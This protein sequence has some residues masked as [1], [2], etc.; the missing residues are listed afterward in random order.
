M[1]NPCS[2]LLFYICSTYF[3]LIWNPIPSCHHIS[4]YTYAELISCL[5]K[6]NRKVLI[7]YSVLTNS[8]CSA[9]RQESKYASTNQLKLWYIKIT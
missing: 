5:K 2:E 1:K 7:L 8:A 3:R 4:E 6:Y 9:K